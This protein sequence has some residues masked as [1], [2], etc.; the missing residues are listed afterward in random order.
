MCV[1]SSGEYME[2]GWQSQL[3][4][5]AGAIRAYFFFLTGAPV[6][7]G[8][9]VGRVPGVMREPPGLGVG[10]LGLG[11]GIVLLYEGMRASARKG[12]GGRR[13]SRGVVGADVEGKGA[14]CRSGWLK[15]G[16]VGRRLR[17]T[18]LTLQWEKK[19]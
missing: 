15:A 2:G 4:Q 16:W 14:R 3:V 12:N 8:V 17:P 6:G 11:V 5:G 7:L 1:D 18:I 9:G 13:K 10:M 19:L